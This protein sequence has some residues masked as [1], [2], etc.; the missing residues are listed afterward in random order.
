M[1]WIDSP[2]FPTKAAAMSWFEDVPHNSY[3][4]F[5]EGSGYRIRYTPR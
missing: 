4:L 2:W 3:M 5:N 1:I